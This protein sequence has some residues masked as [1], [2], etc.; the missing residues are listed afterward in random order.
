MELILLTVFLSMLSEKGSTKLSKLHVRKSRKQLI[1]QKTTSLELQHTLMIVILPSTAVTQQKS[2]V[3]FCAICNPICSSRQ[4]S[5]FKKLYN[6][7][8]D[9]RLNKAFADFGL[10]RGPYSAVLFQVL[11]LAAGSG[12]SASIY[13]ELPLELIQR[14]MTHFL[15]VWVYVF[16][17]WFFFS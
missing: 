17:K 8:L 5:G 2:C 12:W 14:M 6:T 11:C 10:A 4:S 15:H 9:I 1:L 7:S 13:L 16:I 3:N